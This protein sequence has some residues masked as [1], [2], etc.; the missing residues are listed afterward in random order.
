MVQTMPSRTQKIPNKIL[1]CRELKI[2]EEL[3]KFEQEAPDCT[4]MT[5]KL[6]KRIWSFRLVNFLD[7]LQE[8]DLN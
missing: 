8:L 5:H 4:W 7:L 6:M 1:L 2:K 3:M